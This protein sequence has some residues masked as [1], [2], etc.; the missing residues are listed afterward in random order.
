MV[1]AWHWSQSLIKNK[2]YFNHSEAK[3]Q[4]FFLVF[5][6]DGP[7]LKYKRKASIDLS[8]SIG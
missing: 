7:S 4:S 5:P 2:V 3:N 8:L 1:W 6:L